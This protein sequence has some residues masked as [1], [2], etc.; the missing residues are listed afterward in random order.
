MYKLWLKSCNTFL[1][2]FL[3]ITVLL[4]CKE[5]KDELVVSDY[6][7]Y[8]N[9]DIEFSANFYSEIGYDSVRLFTTVSVPPDISISDY[10]HCWITQDENP[11]IDDNKTSFGN[12]TL[13]DFTIIST[14]TNYNP[15]TRY[16]GRAYII[17][18]KG[19]IYDLTRYFPSK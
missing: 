1:T 12:T 14:I 16:Y 6:L 10:G 5:E 13:K 17:T 8:Y 9:P 18:N 7:S 2:L 19:I 4:G 11:T 3:I 15:W